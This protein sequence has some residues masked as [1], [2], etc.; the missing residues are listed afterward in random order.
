MAASKTPRGSASSKSP[1]VESVLN[2][3]LP[4]G[5]E[6]WR[7][8]EVYKIEDIGRDAEAQS[9]IG[10]DLDKRYVTEL[11]EKIKAGVVLDP[12]VLWETPSNGDLCVE[13]NHRVAAYA[14]LGHPTV[15]AY[16]V[17]LDSVDEARYISA[18]FNASHGKRLD[19]DAL[20]AAVLAATRLR[21]EPTAAQLAKDYGVSASQ[22]GKIK[23]EHDV[24]TRLD[25]L[26][27]PGSATVTQGLVLPLARINLDEPLRQA[28]ELVIDAGMSATDTRALVSDV[29]AA[30]SEAAML[31]VIRKARAEMAEAISTVSSGRK[32]SGSPLTDL[33][34]AVGA[35]EKVIEAF[36]DPTAWLPADD[37][38]LLPW[39]DRIVKVAAHLVEVAKAYRDVAPEAG[40]ESAA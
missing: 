21:P 19:A 8:A 16:L 23:S 2:S 30:S 34:R 5:E 38:V 36:P 29:T 13:G 3:H 28:T 25:R 40:E 10:L 20:K 11:A 37:A 18:V 4:H 6:R 33:R 7:F 17:Q 31:D 39:A 15:P 26:G 12:V 9:R 35:L 24:R 1:R 32:A 22:V 14:K 27:V